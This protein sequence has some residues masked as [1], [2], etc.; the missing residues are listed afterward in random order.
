VARA[1]R[2]QAEKDVVVPRG[3]NAVVVHAR[4]HAWVAL[5]RG[6]AEV[7]REQSGSRETRFLAEPGTYTL[8][9]DGAIDSVK[10][11]TIEVPLDPFASAEGD[12]PFLLT[13]TSDAPDRHVVDGVGE[14]AAD[15]ESSATITVAKVSA[16]GEP[17]T[18]RADRDEVFLRTTGGS[19]VAPSKNDRI[20][21]VKLKAGRASFRLVAESTP[22]LVTVSAIGVGAAGPAEI[23][24]EFV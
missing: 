23:Q 7:L 16:A 2:Q 13:L 8:R 6:G 14:I 20:R 5:V 15:G 11:A 17:L 12:A 24:I 4:D 3:S 10:P 22:R 21:S 18:R 19:V 9:T 1:R